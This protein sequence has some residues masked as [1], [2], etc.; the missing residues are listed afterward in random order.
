MRRILKHKGFSVF[1]ATFVT[2]LLSGVALAQVGVIATAQTDTTDE[3]ASFVVVPSAAYQDDPFIDE[4]NAEDDEARPPSEIY[5]DDVAHEPEEHDEPSDE[6]HGESDVVDTTKG[7]VEAK[8]GAGT[9][10]EVEITDYEDVD[11]P[12]AD[13]SVVLEITSPKN[14]AHVEREV[15]TFKGISDPDAV[16][17][18]GRYEARMDDEGHWAIALVLRA[19]KNIMSF[20][21]EDGAGNV[22]ETSVTVYFDATDRPEPEPEPTFS[23]RQKWEVSDDDPPMNLYWGTA[24]PGA[25]IFV[26]SEFGSSHTEANGDGFWETKVIFEG[27]PHAEKFRV[28]VEA[29]GGGRAEFSMKVFYPGG[30]V[31]EHAFTANQVYGSCGEDI[32]YDVFWGTAPPGAKIWIESPYG[33]GLTHADEHGDWELRVEFPDAPGGEV[34]GVFV[35]SSDGGFADFTFVATGDPH[36]A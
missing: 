20:R 21:A 5:E 11:E 23:A 36:E 27:A 14:G 3:E 2:V 22:A 1:L 9:K 12:D 28:V 4:D 8:E 33:A 24:M 34:F 16:V 31:E 6:H 15:I 35:E 7:D 25:E 29:S 30:G 13:D 10:D 17:T 32:P 26:G 18:Y 19:G